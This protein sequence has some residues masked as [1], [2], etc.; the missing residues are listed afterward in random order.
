MKFLTNITLTVCVLTVVCTVL[1]MLVPDR[2]RREIRSVISLIA[3][4]TIGAMLIGA[5][6]ED[7]SYGLEN[8]RF[9]SEAASHDRLVQDELE[10]RIG[11]YIASFLS[12]EG[13]ECKKVSVR[14]TID[15]QRRIS[16]TEASLRLDVSASE[17]DSFVRALIGEKIGEIDVKI[18]YEES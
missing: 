14:T 1:M 12:E 6:F 8:L 9:D 5:D 13:V 15:E 16:I 10:T 7:I 11:E 2:F 18:S 4:V 17:L 3:A